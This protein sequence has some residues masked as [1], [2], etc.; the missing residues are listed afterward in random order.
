MEKFCKSCGMPMDKQEDFANEDKSSNYCY[1]CGDKPSI[2]NKEE[3]Y[4]DQ[5]LE[6]EEYY[7]K[8]EKKSKVKE[9]TTKKK[10][11]KKKVKKK[12]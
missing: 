6:K 1:Y 10:T 5:V 12:K 9:K 4:N 7:N 2:Y 3:Q 11:T 8:K